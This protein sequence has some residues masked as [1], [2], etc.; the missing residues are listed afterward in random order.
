[1]NSVFA[2]MGL[3]VVV[4]LTI[5]FLAAQGE[6]VF[7]CRHVAGDVY[8]LYG[9]GGNIGFLA[10]NEG[11]LVVDSQFNSVADTLLTI[12]KSIS[13]KPVKYLVNTHYHADH[14]GGNDIIGKGA[15]IIMHPKCKA[16]KLNLLKLAGL[17]K[18][19]INRVMVWNE[20]MTIKL[21]G[22]TV[23]LL[24]YGPAH[25][26]GDLIV[27]FENA[28]VVHTGDLFF[29][30][31]PPYIDVE[32]GSDT[33]NWI[34]IIERLCEDYPDYLYIPGHGKVTDAEHFLDLGEYLRYLRT[35]V[36]ASIQEGKS[37][38]ET[39]ESINVDAYSHLKDPRPDGRLTIE[40][41]I[42]WIYDEIMR[43]KE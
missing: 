13:A 23:R 10:T 18:G 14:T 30:G 40:R 34:R 8:C 36:V 41:N 7:D 29:N 20:G 35:E 17:E 24:H 25:T 19:Y 3:I 27:V 9:E 16:T 21:G 43:K 15:E 42:G 31:W 39:I 28:K 22:E 12:M 1:M 26:S 6:A 5:S 38:E 11:L 2:K 32:D 37:K 4:L 33:E